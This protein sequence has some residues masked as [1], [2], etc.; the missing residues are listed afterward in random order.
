MCPLG[1]CDGAPHTS[2]FQ[3]DAH[4]PGAGPP[5]SLGGCFGGGVLGCP[6]KAGLQCMAA[7]PAAKKKKATAGSDLYSMYP[8]T[9]A[10]ARKVY[11]V[12]MPPSR[13]LDQA[14]SGE[15]KC[16]HGHAVFLS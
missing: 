12:A 7:E 10:R 9:K 3:E 14:K 4:R 13:D 15:G 8:R 5:F 6:K 2:A 1:G 11:G 16:S